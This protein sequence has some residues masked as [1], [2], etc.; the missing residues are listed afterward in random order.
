MPFRN[1]MYLS[2]LVGCHSKKEETEQIEPFPILSHF[3]NMVDEI[4][5][6]NTNEREQFIKDALSNKGDNNI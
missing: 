4:Q 2:I 3:L 6:Y 1:R 5:S